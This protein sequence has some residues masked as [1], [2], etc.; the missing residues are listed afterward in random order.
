MEKSFLKNRLKINY[1]YET[2]FSYLSKE[3]LSKIKKFVI[4]KDLNLLDSYEKYAMF[5]LNT[6]KDKS[7]LN[8]YLNKLK[9]KFKEVGFREPNLDEVFLKE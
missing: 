3:N 4:F 1:I 6:E 9:L 2:R 5:G 7:S 8:T